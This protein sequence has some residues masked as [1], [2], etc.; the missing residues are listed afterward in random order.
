M[1][2]LFIGGATL[3]LCACSG[4]KNELEGD[5]ARGRQSFMEQGC[6]LCHSVNGVGG[7][8]APTLDAVEEAEIEV[9]DFAARM[10]RGAYAMAA[11]QK[12]ELGYTIELTGDELRDIAAFVGSPEAQIDL[13][14]ED[15]PIAMQEALLTEVFWEAPDLSDFILD[16][17]S[18]SSEDAAPENTDAQSDEE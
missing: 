17:D 7:T 9:S 15:L 8:V 11:L 6:V 14:R 1:R 5:P 10:M 18:G 2:N 12:A 4:G 16:Y 3:M 13:E